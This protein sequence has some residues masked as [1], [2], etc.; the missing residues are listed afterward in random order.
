MKKIIKKIVLH[1]FYTCLRLH[2]D[3]LRSEFEEDA[4]ALKL[5]DGLTDAQMTALSKKIGEA[6]CENDTFW[7]VIRSDIEDK[8]N[9]K[10][11]KNEKAKVAKVKTSNFLQRFNVPETNE[12]KF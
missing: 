11:N 7:S 12:V 10:R 1:K 6:C 9:G 2:K 5:I 8:R 4:E 3:D